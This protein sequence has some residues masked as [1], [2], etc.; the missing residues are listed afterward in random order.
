MLGMLLNHNLRN[1]QLLTSGSFFWTLAFERDGAMMEKSCALIA[2]FQIRLSLRSDS[3]TN[4]SMNMRERMNTTVTIEYRLRIKLD[5]VPYAKLPKHL[6]SSN[7][8]K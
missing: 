2:R 5:L 1:R 4:G 7:A 8:R 6:T 3:R